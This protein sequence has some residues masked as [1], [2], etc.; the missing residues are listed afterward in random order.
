MYN[1]IGQNFIEMI[2][3]ISP[4]VKV[5]SG[6]AEVIIRCF[7]CGDS[8]NLNHTHMYLSVPQNN[9]EISLY[10]CK[11]CNSSGIVN[12]EFLRKIGCNDANILVSLAQHNAEV[13]KLPKYKQLKKIDIYSLNNYYVTDNK[14][15]RIKLD[16]INNRIGS[17]FTYDDIIKL[18]MF[19]NLSDIV[20]PNKLE[21]TRSIDICKQ[22]DTHF[23]GF[24]SYDNSFAILRQV[25]NK[26]LIKSINKRYINYNIINKTTDIKNFYVIPSLVDIKNKQPIKIHIAEGPF[27]ILSIYYNLNNCNMNQNIYIASGGKSYLQ[28]LEFIL[29]E[30]GIINYEIHIYPDKD[31]NDYA[32]DKLILD[33]IKLLPADI[34]VHRNLFDGE[35]DYGVCA[36]MIKDSIRVIRDNIY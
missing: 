22:L 34:I 31:V 1:Y 25:F 11:K 5:A 21:L 24:I 13:L 29:K 3:S 28:A 6:G 4:N 36:D 10:H 2:R 17:K 18:K 20:N 15:S 27:D 12:D 16:Y 8:T 32:L 35:K 9:E 7:Y 33:K 19:I 23:I 14:F 30:T 26:N